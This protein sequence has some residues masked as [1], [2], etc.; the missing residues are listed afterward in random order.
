MFPM[1][2]RIWFTVYKHTAMVYAFLDTYIPN[3]QKTGIYA[4]S[5]LS[6]SL[7]GS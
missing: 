7:S 5:D 3:K 1:P 6:S 2:Q 4:M